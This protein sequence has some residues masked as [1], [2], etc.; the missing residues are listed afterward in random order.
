MR[1]WR[2]ETRGVRLSELFNFL[3]FSFRFIY[4]FTWWVPRDSSTTAA[5]VTSATSVHIHYSIIIYILKLCRYTHV[6]Y[7]I[8][9]ILLYTQT[10]RRRRRLGRLGRRRRPHHSI[11]VPRLSRP[12]SLP[13]HLS[14]YL[15]L[16]NYLCVYISLSRHSDRQSLSATIYQRRTV[17][18]SPCDERAYW[19]AAAV[20]SC[21]YSIYMYNIIIGAC[22]RW[23]ARETKQN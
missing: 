7:C 8:E 4:F 17:S 1:I 20:S 23:P 2:I 11:C 5:A 15:S 22:V 12:L 6:W 21:L 16:S 14:V 10:S 19:T 3:S 9:Y 13:N 18:R